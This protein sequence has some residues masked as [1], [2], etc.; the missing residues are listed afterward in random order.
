MCQHRHICINRRYFV[1]CMRTA[2]MLAMYHIACTQKTKL[3]R[4]LD[5]RNAHILN[6]IITL[7]R[8]RIALWH[9]IQTI[10]WPCSTWI[11]KLPPHIARIQLNQT[12]IC[13]NWMIHRQRHL[14]ITIMNWLV[15]SLFV[16]VRRLCVASCIIRLECL[17]ICI[18]VQQFSNITLSPSR[19]ICP[20]RSLYSHICIST[21]AKL[22]ANCVP[23]W[24][25]QCAL[26]I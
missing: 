10:Q 8:A 12:K 7:I 13:S 24:S 6:V 5:V 17:A 16:C 1:A 2:R 22:N 15:L 21:R 26:C 11:R 19:T 25:M 9:K 18:V 14:Y 23:V 4:G 20:Y 3:N